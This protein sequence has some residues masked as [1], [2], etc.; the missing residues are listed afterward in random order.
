MSNLINNPQYKNLLEQIKS[1]IDSSRQHI[2][3]NINKGLILLYHSIGT[4]I[5]KNQTQYGW[6]AKIIDQ[7]SQDLKKEL[8]NTKGF[9]PQ[10]LKYMKK[11]AEE[12]K[13]DEIGNVPKFKTLHTF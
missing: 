6:G 3:T 7:L 5:I 2:V 10:N 12:Y 4:E 9:S 13:A 8:P 1:Q 11:F